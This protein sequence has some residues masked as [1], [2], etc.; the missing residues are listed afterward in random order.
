[1]HW[2]HAADMTVVSQEGPCS[3]C[4]EC[5]KLIYSDRYRY[6]KSTRLVGMGMTGASCFAPELTNTYEHLRSTQGILPL[7]LGTSLLPFSL[8]PLSPPR[9]CHKCSFPPSFLPSGQDHLFPKAPFV[10]FTNISFIA[11]LFVALPCPMFPSSFCLSLGPPL[12]P[13]ICLLATTPDR[14]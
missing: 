2:I 6:A 9:S 12:H 10:S 5:H 8:V 4:S 7:A 13:C 11:S 14:P 1:M 3:E